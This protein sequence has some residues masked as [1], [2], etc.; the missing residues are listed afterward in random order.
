MGHAR[1]HKGRMKGDDSEIGT[2]QTPQ[3]F[4]GR[5][6][7]LEKTLKTFTDSIPMPTQLPPT[8]YEGLLHNAR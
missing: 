7:L 2:A 5:L 1:L 8:S 6:A 4:D 3:R